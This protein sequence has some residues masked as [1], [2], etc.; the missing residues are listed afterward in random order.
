MVSHQ[1]ELIAQEVIL[2]LQHCQLD[3][4]SFPLYGGVVLL[5]QGQLPAD[6][7]NWMLLTV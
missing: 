3:G 1:G 7:K 5:G 6:E 2:E 4:Q